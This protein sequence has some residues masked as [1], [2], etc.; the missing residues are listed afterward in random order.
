MGAVAGLALLATV[1]LSPSRQV[2]ELNAPAVFAKTTE[3]VIRAKHCE[4]CVCVGASCCRAFAWYRRP[5]FRLRCHSFSLFN[6]F[7]LRHA[8]MSAET[9]R[10]PC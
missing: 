1:T 3:F 2:V 7:I 9:S 6:G 8:Q 4:S 10:A 5:T